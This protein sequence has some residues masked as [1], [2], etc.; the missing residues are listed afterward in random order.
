[1]TAKSL[2]TLIGLA[3]LAVGILGFISNPIIGD[4]PEAI[5]HADAF[6]NGVHIGSGILF[7]LIPFLAPGATNGFMILFGIVYLGLG[8]LG[9]VTMG[10]EGMAKLLGL[11]HVNAADNYLHIGL[12]L[13]ILIAGLATRRPSAS[14]N[15]A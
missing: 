15:T 14:G 1:M 8:I 13:V 3:F 6:H 2:S 5:F 10:S 11:L 4:S 12:G 9:L 7:L